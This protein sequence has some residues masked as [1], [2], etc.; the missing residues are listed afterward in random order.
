MATHIIA[1][2]ELENKI[3]ELIRHIEKG[4]DVIIER[5]DRLFARFVPFTGIPKRDWRNKMTIRPKLLV[6]PENIMEP[7]SDIW[8]GYL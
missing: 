8:E 5:N 7:I 2:K 1:E 6:S 4:D 3:N